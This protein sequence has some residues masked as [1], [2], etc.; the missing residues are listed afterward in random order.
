MRTFRGNDEGFALIITISLMAFLVLLLVA[1]TTMTR[2]ETQLAGNSQ[3]MQIARENARLA[4]GLAVGQLQRYAG[5]DERVT[6]RADILGTSTSDEFN[7]Y[8]TGVWDDVT[9]NGPEVLTWL[10]SGNEDPD[11]PLHFDP[12]DFDYEATQPEPYQT[13]NG[14]PPARNAATATAAGIRMV[15]PGTGFPDSSASPTNSIREGVVVPLVPIHAP[16]NSFPGVSGTPII[17]R[18]GYWVADQ[19][20]KASM[21]KVERHLEVNF[22]DINTQPWVY[23]ADDLQRLRQLLPQRFGHAAVFSNLANIENDPLYK[24]RLS[25]VQSF[26]QM[27]EALPPGGSPALL[28]EDYSANQNDALRTH[29]HDLTHFNLGVLASTAGHGLKQDLSFPPARPDGIDGYMS[30]A[31]PFDDQILPPYGILSPSSTNPGLGTPVMKI[32]PVLTEVLL[33][34]SVWAENTGGGDRTLNARL[35]ADVEIW[36]PYNADLDLTNENLS[37]VLRI[38]SVSIFHNGDPVGLLNIQDSEVDTITWAPGN[39]GPGVIREF[40]GQIP[41]IE[42]PVLDGGAPLM[43]GTPEPGEPD[44]LHLE[45]D[46]AFTGVE[47]ELYWE[48][49]G[50]QELLSTFRLHDFDSLLTEP[51]SAAGEESDEPR[52]GFYARMRDDEGL[53]DTEEWLT[54]FD[55]RGFVL[56]D[57]DDADPEALADPFEI[58]T[59]VVEAAI[60]YAL[61]GSPHRLLPA[62]DIILFELPLQEVVNIGSLQHVYFHRRGAY[63]LGNPWGGGVNNL[64]DSHF[65][66][67]IPQD[68]AWLPESPPFDSTQFPVP[69][70]GMIPYLGNGIDHPLDFSSGESLQSAQSARHLLL[71]GMFNINSTS[72]AAWRS[73]LSSL[74]VEQDPHNPTE[75]TDWEYGN[76]PTMPLRNAVMRF[77]QTAH[78]IGTVVTDPGSLGNTDV[79]YT[80]GVRADLTMGDIDALADEIVSLLR[81]R[82]EPFLSLAEFV[83]S[84]LVQ[85]AIDNVNLN[86]SI[87]RYSPAFITQADIITLMA[88]FMLARS[89]TFL[90]RA[91][92]DSINPVTNAV[93]GRAWCEAIVQR[94]PTPFAPADENNNFVTPSDGK[95]FGRKFEIIY[96]RWLDSS[97]L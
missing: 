47:V 16:N 54:Y 83:N 6:A 68:S 18:Y 26:H 3:Q 29:F 23:D 56:V 11:F 61:N 37:V 24:S 7:P 20:T 52:F 13:P 44:E 87:P 91:Y 4:M 79:A 49:A 55:P 46:T 57:L 42:R 51:Y 8:W 5:L 76:G 86:G 1:L 73:I 60:N 33:K 96:F 90:I 25:H 77:S 72:V 45:Y 50:G 2:V 48:S 28:Y 36:N 40:S 62:N 70:T 9:G 85:E 75:D 35:E 92:G 38:P 22:G 21:A 30:L 64:F 93:E 19:G 41:P 82:G 84:G 66:S 78:T 32:A 34:Y 58:E 27:R 43:I 88:P 71:K 97:E 10:V 39:M 14:A 53:G 12:T 95:L 17:G 69:H 81:Q 59:D 89:D 31:Y 74:N 15:G 94:V 67:T 80:Q 65:I 63:A